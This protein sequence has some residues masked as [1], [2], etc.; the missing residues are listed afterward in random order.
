MRIDQRV[1][2]GGMARPCAF[3]GGT[4]QGR[5]LD[6]EAAQNPPD[7]KG[8]ECRGSRAKHEGAKH[9]DHAAH[10]TA[11]PAKLHLPNRRRIA[12]AQRSFQRAHAINRTFCPCALLAMME[13]TTSVSTTSVSTTSTTST[14]CVSTALAQFS[15]MCQCEFGPRNIMQT[16]CKGVTIAWC[17]WWMRYVHVFG[18]GRP[19]AYGPR[20]GSLCVDDSLS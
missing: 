14:T 12:R 9:A 7:D 19:D 10:H 13:V 3:P 8:S 17:V 5:E 18:R 6:Q 20:G 2:L 15:H 4:P 11:E 16:E 1:V